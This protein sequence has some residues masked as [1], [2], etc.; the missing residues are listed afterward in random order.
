MEPRNRFRGIDSARQDGNRFLGPLK[1]SANTDSADFHV[2]WLNLH[3]RLKFQRITA[4]RTQVHQ[5]LSWGHVHGSCCS[6]T[7]LGGLTWALFLVPIMF[8]TC[9]R[10]DYKFRFWGRPI[11]NAIMP[12][13]STVDQLFV[14]WYMSFPIVCNSCPSH[15]IFGVV[16]AIT[17]VF[18]SWQTKDW[19]DDSCGQCG[20]LLMLSGCRFPQCWREV[21]VFLSLS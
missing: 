21:I 15:K 1:R 11:R 20:Q 7:E 4:Q 19:N 8:N 10:N 3:L 18:F 9:T 13:L 12:T 6:N 2:T 5:R 14:A 16:T 17:S